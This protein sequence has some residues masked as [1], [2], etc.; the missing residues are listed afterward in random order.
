[1]VGV[2]Y[3]E[4]TGSICQSV[5]SPKPVYYYAMV[6]TDKHTEILVTEYVTND[7]SKLSRTKIILDLVYNTSTV[8]MQSIT[9]II[10]INFSQALINACVLGSNSITL[11]CIVE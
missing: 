7:H 2:M 3:L 8:M 10:T 9:D 5:G 11:K 6:M 1:M 4:A